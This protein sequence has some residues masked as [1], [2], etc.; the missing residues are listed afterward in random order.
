MNLQT[1]VAKV[2]EVSALHQVSDVHMEQVAVQSPTATA[3]YKAHKFLEYHVLDLDQ[4]CDASQKRRRNQQLIDNHHEQRHERHRVSAINT[5][6][7]LTV[8]TSI[9]AEIKYAYVDVNEH[10]HKTENKS[11]P[12][13]EEKTEGFAVNQEA[14]DIGGTMVKCKISRW[15]RMT[16]ALH[17]KRMQV[18]DENNKGCAA[19]KCTKAIADA[20]CHETSAQD[21]ERGQ[22]TEAVGGQSC[23]KPQKICRWSPV[24]ESHTHASK[25][26]LV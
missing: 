18:Y 25:E 12:C 16:N 20:K 22:E 3:G 8:R 10:D 15:I 26:Q 19:A 21:L 23:E 5:A 2:A 24:K 17:V 4:L 14:H 6:Q 1:H 9:P 11:S 7:K 13:R